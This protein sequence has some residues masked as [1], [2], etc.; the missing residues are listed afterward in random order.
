MWELKVK[1]R[2]II[3]IFEK[4]TGCEVE[5]VDISLPNYSVKTTV[6]RWF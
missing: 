3:R 1:L 5:Y 4:A 6:G 2:T